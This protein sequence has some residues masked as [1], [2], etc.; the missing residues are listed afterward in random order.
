MRNTM[1]VVAKDVNVLDCP[2]NIRAYLGQS[3]VT[4]GK[5]YEV[6]AVSVYDGVALV[7]IIDDIG[8]PSWRPGWLF[9]VSDPSIPNDWICNVL[10]GHLSLVLGPEFVA[11]N[12][13][14]YGEMVELDADQVDRFWKRVKAIDQ[15]EDL[16]KF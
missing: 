2:P 3:F 9:D 11:K 8:L 7:Q 1:Q 5:C 12:E 6:Y 16:P 4:K 15:P 14:A 13:D 10:H